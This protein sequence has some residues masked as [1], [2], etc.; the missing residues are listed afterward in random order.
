MLAALI[1]T[2]AVLFYLLKKQGIN[3]RR[4][5]DNVLWTVLGG[6]VGSRL[7]YILFH[8]RHYIN[9]WGEMGQF[10]QGGMNFFGMLIGA[11]IVLIGWLYIKKRQEIWQWLDSLAIAGSLGHAIGMMGALVVGS[12]YGKP[13]SSSTAFKIMDFPDLVWR[14]PT[15]I[16][17]IVAA[18]CA[19]IILGFLFQNR[20]WRNGKIIMLGLVFFGITRFV[21][22]FFR[23]PDIILIDKFT[24]AHLLNLIITM[25]G[26][27]G[28]FWLKKS[29]I[30]K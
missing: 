13:A 18:L 6:I 26:V 27:I 8:V 10:W 4:T 29:N 3:A 16:Y 23:T 7:V 5:L 30:K 25:G 2:I 1:V 24:L 21:I 17:E 14:Y 20:H 19:F 22:E 12:D 9:N 15:Q 11:G 28:L